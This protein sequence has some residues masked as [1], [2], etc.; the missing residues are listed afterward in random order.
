MLTQQTTV[1]AGT[2]GAVAGR[3]GSWCG[4]H[5][6]TVLTRRGSDRTHH[7]EDGAV[8]HKT[9]C[10]SERELRTVSHTSMAPSAAA[11]TLMPR[12]AFRLLLNGQSEAKQPHLLGAP[13]PF[14]TP[15]LHPIFPI[16]LREHH[17]KT[18]LPLRPFLHPARECSQLLKKKQWPTSRSFLN[19]TLC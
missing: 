5:N 7:V 14:Q 15:N 10:L 4:A 16:S 12:Q 1:V 6:S 3:R 18:V 11:P 8:Q 13:L 9:R 17:L 19:A 2:A